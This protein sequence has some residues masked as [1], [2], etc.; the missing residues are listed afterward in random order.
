[1][2]VLESPLEDNASQRLRTS[3]DRYGHE[4]NP[5]GAIMR[6][7]CR[8]CLRCVNLFHQIHRIP[9]CP[10]PH[11]LAEDEVDRLARLICEI[12]VY[13]ADPLVKEDLALIFPITVACGD[14]EV[15]PLN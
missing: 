8:Q 5:A 3:A 12:E 13:E 1:M 7:P 4:I 14:E 10:L 6:K 9:K 11:V 15:N 2:V